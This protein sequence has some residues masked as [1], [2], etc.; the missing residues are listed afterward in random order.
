MLSRAFLWCAEF[1]A[2]PRLNAK[3]RILNYVESRLPDN[4]AGGTLH[5]DDCVI[6]RFRPH[7]MSTTP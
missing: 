4:L 2:I 1:R 5:G 7:A 3:M 6:Q